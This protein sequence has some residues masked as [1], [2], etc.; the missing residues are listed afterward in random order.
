[1][2]GIYLITPDLQDTQQ[3]LAVTSDALQGGVALLQYRNKSASA[4]LR[5]EQATALLELC[6]NSKVPLVI[7]DDPDLA[8]CLGADGV[9]LGNDDRNVSAARLTLGA[10]ALIGASCY[11]SLG[12]ARRARLDGASYIAFG[13]FAT[14]PTKPLATSAD[15]ALLTRARAL[16][17]PV[18]AIGGITPA[19][20]PSL[21]AAGADLLAVISTVYASTKPADAVRA[22]RNAFPEYRGDALEHQSRAV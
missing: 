16:A 11:S 9:H 12:R 7:N 19:L 13:A 3:L 6:R 2:R 20:A 4:T 10:A 14:S 15:A 8:A 22:L 18:V 5:R 1:L 17:L 21:V